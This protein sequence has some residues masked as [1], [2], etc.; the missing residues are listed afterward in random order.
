MGAAA[1]RHG[2]RLTLPEPVW[3]GV[4]AFAQTMSNTA[5]PGVQT[6][7]KQRTDGSSPTMVGPGSGAYKQRTDGSSPTMVGPGSGAFKQRTRSFSH[8]DGSPE[9]VMKQN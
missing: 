8:S 9:G 2:R 5:K 7:Q 3:R 6:A 1:A 4:P